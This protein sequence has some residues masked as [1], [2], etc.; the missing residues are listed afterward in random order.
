MKSIK[1]NPNCGKRHDKGK[2]VNKLYCILHGLSGLYLVSELKFF[3]WQIPRENDKKGGFSKLLCTK[4]CYSD[5]LHFSARM[6]NLVSL[7]GRIVFWLELHRSLMT[8]IATWTI[9][10]LVSRKTLF[11]GS[12]LTQPYIK[13]SGYQNYFISFSQQYFPAVRHSIAENI[14]LS[15]SELI[16]SRGTDHVR[17]ARSDVRHLPIYKTKWMPTFWLAAAS[18]K[19]YQLLA[20]GRW[21]SPGTG[22][23]HH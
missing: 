20:Q 23:L 4:K 17:C 22:F 18:D 21:F 15:V 6:H 9:F 19:V 14:V 13:F 2:I 3:V 11:P 7:F 1:T 10:V 16:N 8:K 5:L 12:A